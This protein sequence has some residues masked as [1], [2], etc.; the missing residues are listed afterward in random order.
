M[1]LISVVCDN[2]NETVDLSTYLQDVRAV[3]EPGTECSW[4]LKEKAKIV[5]KV[6]TIY[7][8]TRFV[9]ILLNRLLNTI[10]LIK[11]PNFLSFNT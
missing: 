6:Y 3:F 9:N 4:C 2:N 5:L 11:R 1:E 7:V 10:K 8:K